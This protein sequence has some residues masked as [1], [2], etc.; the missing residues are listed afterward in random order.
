MFQ[1]VDAEATHPSKSSRTTAPPCLTLHA[2]P[3]GSME[4]GETVY[5]CG[6]WRGSPDIKVS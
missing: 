3:V 2:Y 1:F 4:S 5:T 6:K